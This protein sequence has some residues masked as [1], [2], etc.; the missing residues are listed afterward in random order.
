MTDSKQLSKLLLGEANAVNLCS[1]FQVKWDTMS[2]EE[3][4]DEYK[5]HIDWAVEL[6]YPNPETLRKYFSNQES[7]D[8]GLYVNQKDIDVDIDNQQSLIFVDTSGI[9][10][11]N[12]S[13]THKIYP[14]IYTIGKCELHFIG[15]N[16]KSPIYI[17]GDSNTIT[18]TNPTCFR[19]KNRGNGKD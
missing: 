2:I 10:R 14:L 12:F 19:I 4:V 17:Y 15:N 16:I 5:T 9:V 1:D 18:V 3:L 7:C 11:I 13:L 6:N 8:R